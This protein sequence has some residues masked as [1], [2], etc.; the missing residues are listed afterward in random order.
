MNPALWKTYKSKVLKT[1]NPD[2][3]EDA[4]EQSNEVETDLAATPEDEGASAVSQLARKMQGAGA[5]GW[6]SMS[7]LFSREDEH[8]LL[9]SES[10]P[11]A[12]HPLAPKQEEP[13]LNKRATGFWDSFATKWQQQSAAMKEAESELAGEVVPEDAGSTP[14][15]G[16][17]E[18]G[19]SNNST[20]YTTLGGAEDTGFKWNFVTSKLAELKSKSQAK[21]N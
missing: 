10:Q 20:K 11:A 1:L 7:A 4:V 13:R 17:I 8:K 9:A 18:E 14:E 5:K 16:G 2:F 19:E 12:D 21:T 6:K 15:E 3:E